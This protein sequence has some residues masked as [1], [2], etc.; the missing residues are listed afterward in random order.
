MG[1]EVFLFGKFEARREGELLLWS[2]A[3]TRALL[4]ILAGERGRVFSVD[5]LIEYLWPE[6]EKD[7]KST[8]SNLRAR[9]AELRRI[10]EP[11][12]A[13]SKN[14]RYIETQRG[15]YALRANADCWVDAEEFARCEEQGRRA[16]RAGQLEAAIAL[17][18]KAIALYRGEYLEEDR[19]EEWAVHLR[20]RWRER[21]IELLSELADVLARCGRYREALHTIRRAIEKSPLQEP[22]YRQ[23]MVY[24]YCAGEPAE[25]RRAYL[26]CREVLE[27]ELGERPSSQ[28][29]EIY[30]QLQ[31][32]EFT[33]I[34]ERYPIVVERSVTPD[35]RWHRLP[36]C[37][38]RREWQQL[39]AALQKAQAGRG[40]LVLISGEPGVGKTRLCEEFCA[41]ARERLQ[42]Q[43]LTGRS[44]ELKNP[45]PL[46][47]W[48]EALNPA[49]SQ[50]SREDLGHLHR[51]WLAECAELLPALRS[52]IPQLPQEVSLPAEHR[53]YRLF[54]TFFQILRALAHR[55]SPL[56]ILLDDLQWADEDSVD[57]LCYVI[58]KWADLP[59]MILAAGRS[60]AGANGSLLLTL[61]E[62][63]QRRQWLEE[64]E[65]KR[66]AISD[67]QELISRFNI[68]T[69]L[70]AAERLHRASAGNPLFLSAILQSL[71]ENGFFRAEG[72]HWRLSLPAEMQLPAQVLQL[73]EHR[74]ARVG[75]A[76]Q[77]LLQL[78]ACGVQI[79]LEV[80]E[81]AWEGTSEELFAHLSDLI[82]QGI[83][84]DHQGRYEFS[85]D[86]YREAIY[87]AL[88]EP[89]RIWLHR[90]LAQ[91]LE[92]VY[93]DPTAVGARLA[94]HY[95]RGGQPQKALGCILKTVEIC[96]KRYRVEEGLQLIDQGLSLLKSLQDRLP[97]LNEKAFL[98]Y[99]ARAE[100]YLHTGRLSEAHAAL[101]RLSS[102]AERDPRWLAQVYLLQAQCS[103]DQDQPEES[104]RNAKQA[105]EIYERVQDQ[106]GRAKSLYQLAR[107][108]YWLRDY[109]R[110][111]EI[112]H[113]ACQL[114]EELKDT[115]LLAQILNVL[116]SAYSEMRKYERAL[117]ALNNA[118]KFSSE[119]RD[120]KTESDLL[121]D[122]AAIYWELSDFQNSLSLFH[123]ALALSREI[124]DR[125]GT[126]MILTS[127]GSSLTNLCQHDEA[128]KVLREAHE[129]FVELENPV[130]SARAQRQLAYTLS[131]LGDHP[132]ALATVQK[133]HEMSRENDDAIG[134]A[135][136]LRI[137]GEICYAS[138]QI[139]QGI[140][141]IK[142]ALKTSYAAQSA[143]FAARCHIAL[144]KLYLRQD[145]P[146]PALQ[147]ADQALRS[148][149]ALSAPH[150]ALEAHYRRY[151]AL[152]ALNS[153]QALPALE[154]A[155]TLLL[156]V[157]DKLTD[158]ALRH[159]F[160]NIPLHHEIL[161]H[162]PPR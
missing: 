117:E 112:A 20:E 120:L 45:V 144:S 12:L 95:E 100:L 9:V 37:G 139:P 76:A 75:P 47:P 85:H 140:A 138:D 132:Q 61:K 80:L 2:N 29:E 63:A 21:Y 88:E 38:R 24:A 104:L 13:Q 50:L 105:L 67:I 150:L 94:E 160:L 91:A 90:R 149:E 39:G 114:A 135:E 32:G 73:I 146:K 1:L 69:T 92:S 93:A 79:E 82:A 153:P 8:A 52:I 28:T 53:A 161:A 121:N 16:Q 99:E 148:L 83:L 77:R 15:G 59:L 40:V 25:A 141:C 119:A 4:K 62:H 35:L 17:Y 128:L 66:L 58:D 133:A 123:R 129:I 158:P 118:L 127:L 110:A 33:E 18:E 162:A 7:L 154:T 71:F 89:R 108:Y 157:A 159:S 46:H 27:R 116:G 5:E 103:E 113:Q 98:L 22:L 36:F 11:G 19:Y 111:I 55:R 156:Q 134:Q 72:A 155:R 34:Q 3:K 106:H 6:E 145:R 87:R 54:E 26:R 107:A 122:L 70:E 84:T 142:D 68:E 143:L 49:V 56:L 131:A 64:I 42:A 78:I 65:L 147:A 23:W 115:A 60:G 57:L 124:G 126:G 136:S 101:E 74:I 102:I 30:R 41:E 43:F 137:W 125:L 97:Q 109:S 48:L 86:K 51:S 14:S 31:R 81:R 151:Q 44:L 10:L 152:S 130:E 96:R